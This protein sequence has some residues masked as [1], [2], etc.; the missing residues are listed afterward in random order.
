AQVTSK[1]TKDQSKEKRREDV[2][3]VQEFLKVFPEDLS[4]LLP[5]RQVEI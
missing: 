4:G 3:I 2:L 1:K 5:A